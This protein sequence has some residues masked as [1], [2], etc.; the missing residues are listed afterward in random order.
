MEVQFNIY[1]QE[2]YPGTINEAGMFCSSDSGSSPNRNRAPRV[3]ESGLTRSIVH[4]VGTGNKRGV[5]ILF[6]KSVYYNNEK[7]LQDIEGC[8]V[9][10]IRTIAG[11]KIILNVYASNEECQHLK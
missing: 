6:N 1:I 11:L 5:A 3:K 10:V 8:Y 7:V 9:M 4:H 2:K